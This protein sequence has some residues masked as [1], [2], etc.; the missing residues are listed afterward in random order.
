M[1][2]LILFCADNVLSAV[3]GMNQETDSF[4]LRAF[5]SIEYASFDCSAALSRLFADITLAWG[6]IV[7]SGASD[8]IYIYIYIYS[9]GTW[10]HSL[11]YTL[12]I[13]DRPFPDIPVG[14]RLTNFLPAWLNINAEYW[15][16]NIMKEG[17]QLSYVDHSPPLIK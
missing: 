14:G 1:E 17:L 16:I 3:Y 6:R 11:A 10:G 4:S 8:Y 2:A 5:P 9:K 12:N 15:V 13:P 7:L